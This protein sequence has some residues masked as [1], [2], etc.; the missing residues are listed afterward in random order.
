MQCDAD[1]YGGYG[2]FNDDLYSGEQWVLCGGG[3]YDSD[4]MCDR[5]V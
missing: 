1:R 3:F 2:E 5:F 4:G